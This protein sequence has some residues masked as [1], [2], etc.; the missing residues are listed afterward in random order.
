MFTYNRTRATP[1]LFTRTKCPFCSM[2]SYYA[3]N[4]EWYISLS[5]RKAFEGLVAI[6][7][8]RLF[9]DNEGLQLP[10]LHLPEIPVVAVA[11]VS[12]LQPNAPT[13]STYRCFR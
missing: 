12:P 1:Y 9:D 5:H 7:Q 6:A 13:Q 4:G 11:T 2:A 3:E 8:I 10:P